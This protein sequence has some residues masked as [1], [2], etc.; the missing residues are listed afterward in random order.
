MKWSMACHNVLKIHI[1]YH[2]AGAAGRWSRPTRHRPCPPRPVRRRVVLPEEEEALV[3]GRTR[4][5]GRARR[6]KGM[7]RRAWRST[8]GR[9]TLTRAR[10]SE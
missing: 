3:L 9:K 4:R 1:D 5:M 7:G 10:K 2:P 8:R 6:R